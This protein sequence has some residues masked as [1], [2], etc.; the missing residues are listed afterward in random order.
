MQRELKFLLFFDTPS[1]IKWQLWYVDVPTQLLVSLIG[2]KCV[3][4]GWT[5]ESSNICTARNSSYGHVKCT[6][7]GC[8]V[9]W[10]VHAVMREEKHESNF[11]LCPCSSN[12][13]REI[14]SSLQFCLSLALT[15]LWSI[16]FSL[17]HRGE[18]GC[19]QWSGCI[20]LFVCAAFSVV[21]IFPTLSKQNFFLA[22]EGPKSPR[23]KAEEVFICSY[24]IAKRSV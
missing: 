22:V 18:Q 1:K 24:K 2:I 4:P 12:N 15:A 13:R 20:T 16:S 21:V 17:H 10:G 19:A 23:R 7:R 8:S 5:H 11:V 9:F 14:Q 6:A 3:L